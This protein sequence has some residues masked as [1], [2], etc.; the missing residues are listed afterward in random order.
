MIRYHRYSSHEYWLLIGG[1]YT[2]NDYYVPGTETPIGLFL[3]DYFT[4]VISSHYGSTQCNIIN[5]LVG[6][7]VRL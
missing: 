2:T 6:I 7:L 5:L 4:T 1:S 3:N